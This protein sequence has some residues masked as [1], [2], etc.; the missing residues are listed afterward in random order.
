MSL[1]CSLM[2]HFQ[3]AL[4]PLSSPFNDNGSFF[5]SQTEFTP[6]ACVT[7]PWAS[8]PLSV[9]PALCSGHQNTAQT[10]RTNC[11]HKNIALYVTRLQCSELKPQL[12][13]DEVK[14]LLDSEDSNKEKWSM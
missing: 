2:E 1:S 4:D 6:T 13:E 5:Y 8:H 10:H 12:F 11:H 7:V 14:Y 9:H 3:I